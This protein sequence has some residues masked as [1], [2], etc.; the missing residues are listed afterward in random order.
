MTIEE[1]ILNFKSECFA[2]VDG[3]YCLTSG[4]DRTLKLWN[5][6]KGLLL[7]KYTGQGKKLTKCLVVWLVLSLSGSEMLDVQASHDSSQ[8]ASGGL[9]KYVYIWDVSSADILR[10]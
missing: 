8:V 4:S 5:P 3:N 7:Q 10:R 2:V 1:T 9:D 6:H